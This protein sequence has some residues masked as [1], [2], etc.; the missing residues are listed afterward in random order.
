MPD[1]NAANIE[2]AMSMVA[3]TCRS[4]GVE[5]VDLIARV[6]GTIKNP[7]FTTQQGGQTYETW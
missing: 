1:L 5:V 6:G 7:I 4:M 2:A 3:G